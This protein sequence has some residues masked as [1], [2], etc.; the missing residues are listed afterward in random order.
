MSVPTS[1]DP[2]PASNQRID[3]WLWFARFLKSRTQAT[4]LV[5]S[6][7]LRANGQRIEKPSHMVKPGD[8]L[9]FPLADRIRVIKVLQAGARRGPSPEART[10]YEDLTPAETSPKTG[11]GTSP[12]GEF[13]ARGE[14]RPTKRDRRK[15]DALKSHS[16]L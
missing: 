8:V 10:L 14:G 3:R 13:R 9:T 16:D 15:T 11:S 4:A 2:A 7:K 1:V 6:G 5:A 12:E